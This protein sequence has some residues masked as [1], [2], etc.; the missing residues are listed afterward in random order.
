MASTSPQTTNQQSTQN[1]S[2]KRKPGRPKSVF[3]IEGDI[4][5]ED[6]GPNPN[7]PYARMSP[8]QRQEALEGI[9]AEMIMMRR[10]KAAP[11]HPVRHEEVA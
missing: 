3:V 4:T 6:P 1:Q 10:G 11:A 2:P 8:A 7:N 9:L 5:F